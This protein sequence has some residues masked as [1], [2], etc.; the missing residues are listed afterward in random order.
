MTNTTSV[1][2]YTDPNSGIL[3]VIDFDSVVGESHSANAAITTH[4]VQRGADISDHV[5]PELRKLSLKVRVS[6]SPLRAV[7]Q[8]ISP[9]IIYGT[10]TSTTIQVTDSRQASSV[11]AVAPPRLDLPIVGNVLPRGE[12]D[13]TPG[14]SESFVST[15]EWA[16]LQLPPIERCQTIWRAFSQL[17]LGGVPVS[18]DTDLETYPSML[19]SSVTVPR[20]G[21]NG[22]TF[23][24]EFQEL[25]IARTEKVFLN[26]KNKPNPAVK[27]AEGTITLGI[28]GKPRE[29]RSKTS[30]IQQLRGR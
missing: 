6:N 5:R 12:V 20:E 1:V 2:S 13:V 10:P 11:S 30:V 18:V 24:V 4:A 14:T 17:A 3:V 9:G 28:K 27:R 29:F 26:I 15:Y 19:I 25:K 16:Y 21:T 7:T 23:S 8:G 22:L